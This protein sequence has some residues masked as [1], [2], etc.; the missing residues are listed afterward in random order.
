[1]HAKDRRRLPPLD[2]LVV[3]EAAARHLSFTRASAECFLTQSAV[4]R[5]VAALEDD[6]GAALFRRKHRALELTDDGRRLAAAAN[7]ALAMVREA[8]TAIRAPNRREV[9][10]LTT[11]PGFASLWLIPRLAGFTAAHPG[12]DVRIDAS[13]ERRALAAE[14]FDLAIR[15]V[16]LASG[17]GE[18]MFGESVEPVCAPALLE[19]HPQRLKVPA[20]LRHHVLLKVDMAGTGGMPIE[21]EPWLQAVGA[22]DVEPAAVVTFTH[23]DNAV[24][25]AVEGQGIVLGRRPLIDRLLDAGKLVAPFARAATSAR[26][27]RLVTE[28]AA[29]RR[30]AVQALAGWLKKEAARR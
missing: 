7:A 2:R 16:P 6:L 26:G 30:P 15:Y 17:E 19:Q 25:A 18:P 21:W 8:V 27:Y 28:A 4:S 5:Q 22:A 29:A 3:F 24:A 10:A 23:Y 9:V 11:T 13:H 12:I 20:D 14:G 1:M